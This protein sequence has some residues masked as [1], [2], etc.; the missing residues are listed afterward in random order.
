[1]ETK[2]DTAGVQARIAA[3]ESARVQAEVEREFED[4]LR[5]ARAPERDLKRSV[6]LFDPSLRNGNPAGGRKLE[7]PPPQDIIL[8]AGAP[9]AFSAGVAEL[10]LP[11][12][13]STEAP[14]SFTLVDDIPVSFTL[15]DDIPE[16]P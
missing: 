2:P 1:M 6:A 11:E 7:D 9:A 5:R 10:K 16:K 15:V 12:R 4:V 14:L 13:E 8:R 3:R